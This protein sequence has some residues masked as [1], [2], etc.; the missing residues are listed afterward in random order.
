MFV[1]VQDI[2]CNHKPR[3]LIVKLSGKMGSKKL[4]PGTLSMLLSTS[5]F[6][7]LCMP[8]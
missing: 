3:L 1:Y 4:E 8:T 6:D 5:S 2:L 7:S